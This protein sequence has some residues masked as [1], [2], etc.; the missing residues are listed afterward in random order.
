MGLLARLRRVV[1]YIGVAVGIVVLA[2]PVIADLIES[3]RA[4]LT[5]SQT[6]TTVEHIEA[7][8]KDEL[9]EQAHAYNDQLATHS[10]S[11]GIWPYE[12]QLLVDTAEPMCWVHIPRIDVRLTVHH[13]TDDAALASGAGHLKGTS[14]PVGGASTHCAISAHSG[15]P[16]ARMFDDLHDLAPGDVF[17][18]WTLGDPYAYEVTGSEVVEPD[19]VS[20]LAIQPDEDLCT[21]ITCTPYGVNS[22][23]LLVHA[24]RCSYEDASKAEQPAMYVSPRLWPLVIGL[25]LAGGA[26]AVTSW[27]VLRGRRKA[28]DS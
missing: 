15:M 27:R 19:D 12:R 26:L 4:E 7:S 24:K 20:S 5:I 2:S 17:I 25:V 11:S 9:L 3:L 8:R 10:A 23:R 18:V 16:T 13:G 1:P 14:L 22:Q 6:T 28:A 21:L